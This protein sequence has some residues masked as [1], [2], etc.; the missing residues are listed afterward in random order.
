[1][2]LWQL[3]RTNGNSWPFLLLPMTQEE[4]VMV[5][6]WMWSPHPPLRRKFHQ[7]P[8][9]HPAPWS[10]G[11]VLLKVT[12][13]KTPE[14]CGMLGFWGWDGKR[15]VWELVTCSVMLPGTRGA[16]IAPSDTPAGMRLAQ[17]TCFRSQ[18]GTHL[19]FTW[20]REV[21][22]DPWEACWAITPPVLW[23]N[24]VCPQV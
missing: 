15:G 2:H 14:G 21:R 18:H 20:K 5:P 6:G 4:R 24:R 7:L 17:S 12:S 1:M 16:W 22:K 3:C 10:L 23:E 19:F 8:N 13:P 11:P 9:V